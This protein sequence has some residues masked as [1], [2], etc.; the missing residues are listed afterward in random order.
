[1]KKFKRFLQKYIYSDELP[2]E[3]RLTNAAYLT[4]FVSSFILMIFY[5]FAENSRSLA[6]VIL[7]IN[8]SVAGLF[9]LNN[10]LSLHRLCRGITIA[11]LCFILF[12]AAFFFLGGL[13]SPMPA[14]FVLS[15]VLI[16]LFSGGKIRIP[17]LILHLAETAA[18][19]YLSTLPFFSALFV[20][21]APRYNQYL[22]A[23]LAFTVVGL[24]IGCIVDY[25]R[26]LNEHER[27]KLNSTG[28]NLLYRGKL[29]RMVNHVAELLLYIESE[30]P[31]ENFEPAME[32]MA[33]CIDADRMYIWQNHM[34]N[35]K[36][37]YVQ[38]FEWVKQD[39]GSTLKIK[40]GY[41][42]HDSI[43]AWE[44]KFSKREVVNGPLS[45]LS[46][47]EQQT[48]SGFGI[49][50]IL[51]IPVFLQERFWGFVSFDNCHDEQVYS[52]EAVNMLRSGC[53]LIANTAMREKNRHI[54][55]SRL[56]QQELM[57]GIAQSFISGESMMTLIQEALRRVGEF[58][59][60]N[61]V[62]MITAGKGEDPLCPVY[63]WFSQ[64]QW[65]KRDPS[66]DFKALVDGAFPQRI[67]GREKMAIRF[68]T[69]ILTDPD[70]RLLSLGPMGIKS[71]IWAP[72][73]VNGN[74][75][76]LISVE[77]CDQ[78]RDWTESDAQLIG[79]VSSAIAGAV[80]RDLIEKER[81]AAL[82]QALHASMAKG[83]FLS[84][85]SHEMRTP[86][87]AI[88]GMAAI[89]KK[90]KELERKD[91]AFS[92]IEDASVHLLGVINDI[93][94]MSKIEANK[95]ELSPVSF[96][97][98]KML[99]K[100][101][102]VINFRIE[103][104]KQLFYVTIDKQIPRFL[105]GDD[106]RLAQVIVNL[107]SNAVKFTPEGGAIRL[108]VQCLKDEGEDVL[109]RTEV[110]DTGIGINKDQQER[111]FNS[112]EQAENDTTRKYGGTGL[113]LAISKQIVEMMGGKIW[114]ESE[115]G[116]GSAFIFT[117]RAKKTQDSNGRLLNPEVN[118]SNVRILAVDDDVEIRNFFVDIGERFEIKCDTAGS[119]DE[120]MRLIDERGNYDIYFIDWKMPGMNG[121]ELSSKIQER[122][123]RSVITMISAVTL[124]E[125]DDEAKKAGVQRYLAKPLFPSDI[126][127][128]INICLGISET[129]VDQNQDLGPCR[130]DTN[131]ILLVEDVE[132]NRE[133]VLALL[134]PTGI[135]IDCAENGVEALRMFSKDPDKY[136]MIFM[137]VQMPEMDGYEATRRIRKMDLEKA[138]NIPIVAMTANVFRD[139]I[140]KSL[141]AG[142]DDHVGKPLDFNEV[143]LKLH[144]Y[145]Q[146]NTGNNPRL[147]KYGETGVD[148]SENWKYGLAWSPSLAT[149][150]A[151]IDSQHKQ[152][153]RL[154][155]N[156]ISGY[157][158]G[159]DATML[160][161]AV[162]F[163]I[164]YTRRHFS[165]EEKLQ[166]AYNYPHY[167]E[168]KKLH[169]DF[170][171]KISGFAANLKQNG[172]SGDLADQVHS[173]IVHWLVEHIKKEDLKFAEY[174]KNQAKAAGA[175]ETGEV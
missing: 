13:Y 73:Y 26:Q 152:I 106:Q 49:K 48:L 129:A 118:W 72:V 170:K 46:L 148:D 69:D 57:A 135:T 17:L 134:E 76:G 78:N 65:R 110:V 112:F 16:F 71:F 64:K 12:P 79:S 4:G 42:Y 84:N 44:E 164:S 132:I 37:H 122:G 7:G 155:S 137:D 25:Q 9:F 33:R 161:G 29:L 34:I 107:L 105:V 120:A 174:I 61:R 146:K 116:K 166:I 125:M 87:N 142:M 10:R 68:C 145:L 6:L 165:D 172:P 130:F 141:A 89:G 39:M 15:V 103:E 52:E 22:D 41:A 63:A 35:G 85:M 43:P 162:D 113:G 30:N 121:L 104:R 95:L 27:Q 31:E 147:I 5:S 55:R 70:T 93:L 133:I 77:Q 11:V 119:S 56:R 98:E 50:S 40:T 45:S 60:A 81:S 144:I 38:E 143:L 124:N 169:D 80:A 108:N 62:L 2:L 23:I 160:E 1:M 101:V 102:N 157:Q 154:T 127:D 18:C 171:E 94:D 97:F 75:W 150:D 140:E 173:V 128:W 123:A 149:G 83:N 111:L 19:Y 54:L 86:M 24:C 32:T 175:P 109:L 99:Q 159:Q 153:F 126:A 8:A 91:Y 167:A 156:I 131:R 138:K 168:H 158:G 96:N 66:P 67:S 53:L 20:R 21:S 51:V 3:V 92:K 139:D 151:K 88:I 28:D 117:V 58:M 90:A 14:Y 115:P 59:K 114:V 74:Y 47:N 36:L 82:D 136:D 100:V 163:L